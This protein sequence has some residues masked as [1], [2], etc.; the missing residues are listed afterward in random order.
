VSTA[1]ADYLDDATIADEETLLRRV[2]P[3]WIVPDKNTGAARPS[4]QAFDNGRDGLTM[5]VYLTSVLESISVAPEECLEGHPDYRM[6]GITA[7]VV[8]HE[9]QLVV[10]DPGTDADA[11][12]NPGDE[13]HGLVVGNKRAKLRSRL[14]KAAFWVVAP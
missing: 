13:A 9:N 4:S 5:S 14:A 1:P 12:P 8:R 7:G 2:P 6:A 10:R 3:Q 11:D